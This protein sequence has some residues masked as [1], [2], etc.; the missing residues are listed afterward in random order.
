M[1]HQPP[2]ATVLKPFG[3]ALVDSRIE[4]PPRSSVSGP[5]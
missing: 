5:I 4:R 3:Q 1:T 2:Y